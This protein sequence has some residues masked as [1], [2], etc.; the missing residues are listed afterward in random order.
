MGQRDD[1]Q[2]VGLMKDKKGA[3]NDMRESMIPWNLKINLKE[4][5]QQNRALLQL[6]IFIILSVQKVHFI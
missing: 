2:R 6:Y 1:R 3:R 4:T 5:V